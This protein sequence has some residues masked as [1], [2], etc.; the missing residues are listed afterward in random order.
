MSSQATHHNHFNHITR[1]TSTFAFINARNPGLPSC[2]S[3]AIAQYARNAHTLLKQINLPGIREKEAMV[4]TR[5][6]DLEI[7]RLNLAVSTALNLLLEQLTEFDLTDVANQIRNA[8]DPDQLALI[9]HGK[10]AAQFRR[11]QP[12]TLHAAVLLS[13]AAYHQQQSQF[14]PQQDDPSLPHRHFQTAI[15]NAA[16]AVHLLSH[17]HQD[18]PQNHLDTIDALID[19]RDA[20]A[21]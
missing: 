19:I 13:I 17:L 9:V 7:P 16:N 4:D 15:S 10:Q 1:S 6:P 12:H 20:T 18:H 5:N 8:T 3:P 11:S 2:V 14:Q 21:P